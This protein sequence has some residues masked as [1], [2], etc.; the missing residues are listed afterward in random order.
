MNQISH[1]DPS[2]YNKL[3][4]QK[5]LEVPFTDSCESISS[6]L[7]YGGKFFCVTEV[8]CPPNTNNNTFAENL[9][10]LQNSL[11]HDNRSFSIIMGDF[12]YDLLKMHQHNPTHDFFAKLLDNDYLPFMLKPTRV[13]HSSSTLIDNIFVKSKSLLPN[14]SYTI[15]DGMSDHYPC[16]LS[17]ILSRDKI[18]GDKIYV[19]KHK[20]NEETIPRI[21]QFLLFHDWSS[22]YNMSSSD[23][24][25]YLVTIITE[26]LDLFVPKKTI[27]LH[28][29]EKFREPWLTVNLM[30]Y[31][32]KCKKL[33]T[34][35]KAT[36]HPDDVSRYRCYHN[37]LTRLKLHEKKQHY[38]E[39]FQKIGKNSKLLWNVIN[40]MLKKQ[41]K[42]IDIPQL[43]YRNC[44]LTEPTMFQ[45][46]RY[47]LS[48]LYADD[49][50]IFLVGHSLKFLKLKVQ[51]DLAN[52]SM[53]LR[54]N[55]LKLNVQKTKCVIFN[56]EGLFPN[57]ELMVD[58]EV[59]EVVPA[60]KFLGVILDQ[61]PSFAKQFSTLYD[62]LVKSSFVLRSLSLYVLVECLRQ[63][64]FAYYHSHLTY[65]SVVWWPLLN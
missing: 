13:I 6:V 39:V 63:L 65:C 22:I 10:E 8:Y 1:Y 30:K 24:Y 49:T 2:R 7:S 29:D 40:V 14:Q 45:C 17:Y 50:T 9:V 32:Q 42:K 57:V 27:Y 56:H 31:N 25:K 12:N 47:C 20:L 61:S 46:L 43:F 5:Q 36:G 4:I 21:H 62:K 11:L 18:K 23:G 55:N 52:M 53:W 26:A 41:T 59:I 3:I 60:F 37:V 34:K 35:A 16:L 44:M 28:A 38:K 58:D 48:I 64:Y 33:C 51:S 19:E 54:L 15:L